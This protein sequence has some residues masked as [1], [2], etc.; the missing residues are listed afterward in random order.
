MSFF[1]FKKNTWKYYMDK[2]GGNKLSV[3][4]DTQYINKQ[5]LNTYYVKV[6]Y[7]IHNTNELPDKKFLKKL[8]LIEDKCLVL[9]KSI[10]EGNVAF[11]GV[12]TFGGSSYITF[13]SDYNIKWE[14][15]IDENFSGVSSG[16]Y[17]EDNMGYYNKVLYPE[18]IRG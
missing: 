10:F 6:D 9:I 13:A 1:K 18:Y 3:R 2:L 14:E 16:K 7:D 11:L 12:A 8:Q 4:V 17:L 5:Y 15:L